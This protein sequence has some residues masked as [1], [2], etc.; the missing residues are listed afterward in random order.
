MAHRADSFDTA[1]GVLSSALREIHTKNAS[2]LSFEELYR[3]AYQLVLRKQGLELYDRVSNLEREWLSSEVREK[4][5]AL[6][7]PS[8]L[9]DG[10]AANVLDQ[11]N[12]R[13]VAGERFLLKLKQVWEDHQLCMGMITDVLMYMDRV[14][15]ME[16]RL[17]SIYVMAMCL[18]RDCVLRSP[19][20]EGSNI[21]VA[22]VFE[23][24]VLFMVRLER[25]GMMIDRGLIRHCM[26]MLEGLYETEK[27][28]EPSKLYLTSFEPSFLEASRLFYHAEGQRL[29]AATDA[30]TFC[31]RVAERLREEEERCSSTLS[32][33]TEPK[34]KAVIDEYLIR[35]NIKEVVTQPESGVKYMIDNDRFDDL[36]TVYELVSRVNSKKTALIPAV[37]ARAVELGNQINDAVKQFAQPATATAKSD[38]AKPDSKTKPE[39]KRPV[40]MQTAAAIKWV[41]DVLQLKAKFDTIWENSF[42]RDQAM[43]SALSSSFKDFINS[44]TRSSEYL[45]LFFDENLKKGIKDKTEEEIDSLL[46]KGITLLLYLQDRDLFETYYKKHLS[47]RLLMKRS[48]NMDVERQMISKMKEQVGTTFTQKLEA[49]FKDMTISGDLTSSYKEHISQHGDADPSRINLEISV[50][51]STMWPIEMIAGRDGTQPASCI[52]PQNVELLRQSFEQFYLGKHNGRKLSWQP[53]MGTA[54]IRATFKRSNGRTYRYD[55]NVSTYAMVILLLFQDLPVDESL[56][57]EEIQGKTNIPTNELTRNLQSLAVAPKTRILKKEPMSRDVK[58]TDKFFFNEGFQSQYT[59]IKVGV[60][61]TGGNRVE[62]QDERKETDQKM[63]EERSFGVDAAIVRI[64]KQRKKLAHSQLITEVITQLATRFTPDVHL[65]KKRIESL[66]E[67]EY[68]ERVPDSDPPAYTYVS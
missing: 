60:V 25:E 37:Q 40:N 26:Y 3:N 17:P 31:K 24:T 47:R 38:Q 12:E 52:F 65:I 34:I 54:D 43:E 9:F 28:E 61:S 27:E 30:S 32:P 4:V 67:K 68:L 19:I 42:G 33:V 53:G 22:A 64:M 23:A 21:T 50:L 16:Q 7:A 15:E 57:F 46:A 10:E 56:T 66:I 35:N 13:R 48:A 39:E 49:M 1:W 59:K 20:E 6:I 45:S 18:F 29:L 2:N 8:L 58:P 41:D 44:H 5:T 63:N 36:A 51:T 62:N 11:A 14:L 55:L